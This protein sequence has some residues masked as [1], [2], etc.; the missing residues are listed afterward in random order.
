MPN[1]AQNPRHLIRTIETDGLAPVKDDLRPNTLVIGLQPSREELRDR[2]I[3]RTNAM[4]EAGLVPEIKRLVK[5]YGWDNQ[6]LQAP[7]YKAFRE[8]ISGQESLEDAKQ[9]NLKYDL[10]LAKRQRTWFKRNKS[11]HWL[12]TPV[13]WHNVVATVTTFLNK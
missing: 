6:A 7:A 1:N 2:L 4:L 3:K 9:K 11:I 10:T 13:I 5:A 12:S 8:Y